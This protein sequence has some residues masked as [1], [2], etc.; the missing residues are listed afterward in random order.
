MN[1]M[2]T[3]YEVLGVHRRADGATIRAALRRTA[4]RYHPD[5]HAEDPA[6]EQHLKEA[7][8][9]YQM[10]KNPQQRAAYDRYLKRRTQRSVRLLRTALTSAGL[11]STVVIALTVWLSTPHEPGVPGPDRTVGAEQAKKPGTPEVAAP[12]AGRIPAQDPVASRK[13]EPDAASPEATLQ[14]EWKQIAGKGDPLAVWAFA[15][16]N[17]QAPEAGLARSWLLRLI[18]ATEDASFLNTLRIDAGGVLAERAQQRLDALA[19]P[20]QAAAG[21]EGATGLA[22]KGERQKEASSKGATFYL[23]R[24]ARRIGEA[25]LDRAIADFDEA[26]RLEPGNAAAYGHRAGAWARK[27]DNDRALADYETA[28]RIDPANAVALRDRGTLWRRM[29]AH[30][31]ALL[32]LD[33]AIRLGFSDAAAY[34]ERGQVWLDKANYDRAIADFNQAIKLDPNLA[35]AYFNRAVAFRGK[36]DLSGAATDFQLAIGLNPSFAALLPPAQRAD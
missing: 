7:I 15:A 12:D 27:G 30:D 10:L 22:A 6:G 3:P 20:V 18:E 5:L 11:A 1:G 4:K 29:G 17:P 8:A 14:S 35:G 24:G 9:A 34:N 32:D 21:H 25:D 19:Q 33:Q 26:I 28:I 31:R 36:G 23:E 13:E 2:K 16:R